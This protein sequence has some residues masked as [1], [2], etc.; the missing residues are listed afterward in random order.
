MRAGRPPRS[1]LPNGKPLQASFEV[2]WPFGR[3][4]ELERAGPGGSAKSGYI[5]GSV[6]LLNKELSKAFDL[7]A[8][9]LEI[10][11]PGK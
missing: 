4:S 7:M 10:Q 2:A 6:L 5:H 3:P 11:E 9:L 8:D 1:S